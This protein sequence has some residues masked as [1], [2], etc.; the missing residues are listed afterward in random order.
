M[1]I[2]VVDNGSLADEATILQQRYPFITV[3][4]S[5]DN[6]GYA[7]G[8][9]LGIKASHGKYLF[10]INN[11]TL[12]KVRDEERKTIGENL[13]QP[14]IDRLESKEDIGVVCPKIRFSWNNNP[15]QYAGYT[16]LSSITL[17]NQPI[18]FGEDDHGQYDT[19][20]PETCWQH[21]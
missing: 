4:R 21:V 1:E 12:F 7:G 20:Q 5:S 9:N 17:R 14:L 15:I 3:V 2:I 16:S 6:L 18:G 11:D 19:P 8:N 10:F 13:F